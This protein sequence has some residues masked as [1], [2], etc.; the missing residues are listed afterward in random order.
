MT[1]LNQTIIF[2]SSDTAST[3]LSYD[4]TGEHHNI[5]N[6]KRR[7]I[8]PLKMM[9]VPHGMDDCT[10]RLHP[11]IEAPTCEHEAVQDRWEVVMEVEYPPHGPE[12]GV[13]E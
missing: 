13:V 7:D 11:D 1:Y 10:V 5:Q 8:S 3:V 2:I 12:W 6:G 9:H 4:L